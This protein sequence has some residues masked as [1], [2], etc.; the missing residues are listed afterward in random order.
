MPL[1]IRLIRFTD[2]GLEA[3]GRN[4][5]EVFTKT[6][7]VLDATGAKMVGAYVTLGLYDVVSIL[8]AEDD[9]H[10]ARV[11]EA[12]AQL[13]YYITVEQSG[14]VVLGEFIA[15]SKS[16][17]VFVT[18]WLQSRKAMALTRSD[19]S[20]APGG[21]RAA[22]AQRL[23]EKGIEERRVRRDSGVGTFEGWLGGEGPMPVKNYTLNQADWSMTLTVT[24]PADSA[25]GASLDAVERNG[26]I[27][28]AMLGLVA[29]RSRIALEASLIRKDVAA[30]G[31][32]EVV[33]KAAL[34]KASFER[35]ARRHSMPRGSRG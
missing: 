13:G 16:A 4:A 21:A 17:P 29:D 11:D 6:V 5:T 20:P 35:V 25:V 2:T 33:V 10:I 18:A 3:C 1:F 14:I 8:E 31:T 24:L 15:L 32:H 7:G 22:S 30:D 9:A 19:G 28:G 23:R 27:K 34:P 26:A 12:I